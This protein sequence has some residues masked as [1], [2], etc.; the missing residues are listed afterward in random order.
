MI[1]YLKKNLFNTKQSLF[2]NGA[3]QNHKMNYWKQFKIYKFTDYLI[4]SDSVYDYLS[5]NN[6]ISIKFSLKL[7]INLMHWFIINFT[8][9]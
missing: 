5:I 9:K 6:H 4:V 3:F 7:N 8:H 2:E 1:Y